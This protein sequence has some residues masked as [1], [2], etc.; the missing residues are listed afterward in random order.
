ME[1]IDIQD[2]EISDNDNTSENV[3][4]DSDSEIEDIEKI[5]DLGSKDES[6][7][8]LLD[9]EGDK[10]NSIAIDDSD[11][12]DDD[13]QK[14][15]NGLNN[16][17]LDYFHS[18]TNIPNYLEIEKLSKIIKDKNG[19]IMIKIINNSNTAV[20]MKKLNFRTKSKTN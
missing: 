17:Y 16:N 9:Y 18:E 14:F 1:E 6:N 11:D 5:P 2:D 19:N 13:Y 3:A 10:I 20:N 7:F 4:S 12:E 15:T 8:N